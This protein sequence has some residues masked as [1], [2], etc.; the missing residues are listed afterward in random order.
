[1]CDRIIMPDGTEIE[2]INKDR[3]CLCNNT[4]TEILQWVVQR[5][6]VVEMGTKLVIVHDVFG[7]IATIE[8]E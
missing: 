4:Q 3:G 7:W 6:P 5:V 8:V 2:S 1:M